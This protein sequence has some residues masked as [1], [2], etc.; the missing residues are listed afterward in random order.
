MA[1]FLGPSG[2]LVQGFEGL[3]TFGNTAVKQDLTSRLSIVFLDP[4]IWA[5]A[6]TAWYYNPDEVHEEIIHPEVV[7][8]W[9]TICQALDVM[10]KHARSI[11][12][13]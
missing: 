1:I 11:V 7:C 6:L 13:N 4:C 2:L 8:L 9:P 10:I 12:K 5:F 3:C